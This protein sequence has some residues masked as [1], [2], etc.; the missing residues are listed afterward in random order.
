M[1]TALGLVCEV[2][3]DVREK[4]VV[5]CERIESQLLNFPEGQDISTSL[6]SSPNHHTSSSYT[7]TYCLFLLPITERA[8]EVKSMLIFGWVFE[9]FSEWG[10]LTFSVKSNE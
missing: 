4:I 10:D 1:V 3:L 6:S 7:S 2:A 8:C 9:I 5:V